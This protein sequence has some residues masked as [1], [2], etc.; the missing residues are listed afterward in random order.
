MDSR[1]TASPGLS[2]D[3]HGTGNMTI[4][5]WLIPPDFIGAARA[6][7]AAGLQRSQIASGANE[8]AGRLGLGYAQLAQESANAANRAAAE[9]EQASAALALRRDDSL[10]ERLYRGT[11]L[12]Q[13]NRGLDIEQQRANAYAG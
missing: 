10:A 3:T 1:A 5:P 9:R 2:R 7:A 4:A 6:G 12:E 13:E 8:A 11:K